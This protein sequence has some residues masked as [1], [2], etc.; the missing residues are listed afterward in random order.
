MYS[1]K[2]TLNSLYNRI[3]DHGIAMQRACWPGYSGLQA[4]HQYFDCHIDDGEE[5]S[6]M[7]HG[8]FQ[9]P[10]RDLILDFSEEED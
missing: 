3:T 8:S 5:S 2:T 4:D 7:S 1:N 10:P 9:E 6:N